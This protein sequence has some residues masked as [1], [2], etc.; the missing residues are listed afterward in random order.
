MF[1]LNVDVIIFAIIAIN[2]T[3]ETFGENND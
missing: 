3:S 2:I 1:F